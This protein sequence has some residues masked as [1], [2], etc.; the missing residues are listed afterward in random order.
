MV[1]EETRLERPENGV[2]KAGQADRAGESFPILSK[3]VPVVEP[4]CIPNKS[5]VRAKGPGLLKH[6]RSG[7]AFV[8]LNGRQV[9]LGRYGTKEAR[10]N[11]A[12]QGFVWVAETA[13]V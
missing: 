10:E 1:P 3:P 6:K 11:L 7:R 4:A 5:R 8:V 2:L 13:T 9:Y 12:H